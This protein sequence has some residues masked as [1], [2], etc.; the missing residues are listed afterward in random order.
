[1]IIDTEKKRKL[2]REELKEEK[3]EQEIQ[4]K[5]AKKNRNFVQLYRDYIPELRWLSNKS[6]LAMSILFFIMEHMDNKNALACSYTVLEEHFNKGRTTIFRAIK[7]LEENGFIS[8]LKMGN[9]NAYT[10]NYEVAWTTW[11]N[12]KQYAKFDGKIMI[13]RKENKDY[14]YRSQF[15]RFKFL[16]QKENIKVWDRNKN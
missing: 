6:G 15:D 9:C 11:A 1:M 16:R 10:L 8:I 12:Q 7:L 14:E 3:I 4:R 13:S 2:R 5:E